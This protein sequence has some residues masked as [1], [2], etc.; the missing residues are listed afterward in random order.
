M[1]AARRGGPENFS[2]VKGRASKTS[3][4]YITGLWKKS[5]DFSFLLRSP[6]LRIK[7]TLPKG[8]V[9]WYSEG[10][11]GLGFLC[12]N[13]QFFSRWWLD[14]HFFSGHMMHKQFFST[15]NLFMQFFFNVFS[16]VPH[17]MLS[18]MLDRKVYLV[19]LRLLT[20]QKSLEVEKQNIFAYCTFNVSDGQS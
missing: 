20:S 14:K 18:W 15:L 17:Q 4:E 10:E 6:T 8:L 2:D 3:R 5:L 12:W 9:I 19:V 16:K 11:G 7:W 13:K 1:V